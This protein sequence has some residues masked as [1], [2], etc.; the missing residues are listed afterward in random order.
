MKKALFRQEDSGN[1]FVYRIMAF[2]VL[3]LVCMYDYAFIPIN[4]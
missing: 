2:K 3:S 4:M 1:L